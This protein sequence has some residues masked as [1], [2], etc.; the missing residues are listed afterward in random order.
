MVVEN[1]CVVPRADNADRYREDAP[2]RVVVADGD[3][4]NSGLAERTS[5]NPKPKPSL[6][7]RPMPPSCTSGAATGPWRNHCCIHSKSR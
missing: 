3:A 2:L 4:S 5:A 1:R 7:V 6:D